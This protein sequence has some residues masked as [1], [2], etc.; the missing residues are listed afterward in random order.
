MGN[1]LHFSAELPQ[2]CLQ[3]IDELWPHV[4]KT[5]QVDR[6]DLGPLTTTFLI[7]MSMPIINLPIERIERHKNAQIERY[8]DDRSIDPR[9]AAAVLDTLGGQKLSNAPFYLP[10]EWSFATYAKSPPLNIAKS[11]P[12]DLAS[13]LAGEKAAVKADKMPVSQWCSIIRNAMAHGGIAYL[14]ESGRTSYGEPVKMYAFVS[15]KFDDIE[16]SKL[17]YLNVLRVSEVNY[18]KFLSRWVIWLKSSGLASEL[19]AA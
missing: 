17:L 7:S 10:G 16:E 15:G 5:H 1:P 8:A 2:R 6:P 12:D 19:A 14:N 3:L 11:I 18:R 9:V 13:E 4:E